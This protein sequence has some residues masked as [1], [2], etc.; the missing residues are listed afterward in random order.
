VKPLDLTKKEKGDAD[1]VPFLSSGKEKGHLPGEQVASEES[2]GIESR[3]DV[4]VKKSSLGDASENGGVSGE[5]EH[6]AGVG[7]VPYS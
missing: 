4:D 1:R 6:Q 5:Q 7:L 3:Q 2:G